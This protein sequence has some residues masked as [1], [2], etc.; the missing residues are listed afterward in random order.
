MPLFEG[1]IGC[2]GGFDFDLAP[3]LDEEGTDLAPISDFPHGPDI[4]GL[5]DPC[6]PFDLA[7]IL[8]S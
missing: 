4:L 1:R 2:I 7:A 3:E 6:I 5:P 8:C